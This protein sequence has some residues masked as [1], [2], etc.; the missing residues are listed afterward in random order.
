[1][2]VAWIALVL[3]AGAC[4]STAGG[5][6]PRERGRSLYLSTCAPCHG[7][8][9]DGNGPAARAQRIAPRNFLRDELRCAPAPGTLPSA[10]ALL[11]VIT[12]GLPDSAMPSFGHLPEE[13]RRALV[14]HV[15]SLLA[16]RRSAG[17]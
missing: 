9:G 4:K 2:R 12:R 7:E 16:R 15:E 13:D 3:L 5:G 10:E 1:V 17:K 8:T 14:M 6:T 11:E